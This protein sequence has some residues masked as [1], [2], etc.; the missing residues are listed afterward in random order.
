M[1]SSLLSW[2]NILEFLRPF[3]GYADGHGHVP[4]YSELYGNGV[5]TFC[6]DICLGD[7]RYQTRTCQNSHLD[8]SNGYAKRTSETNAVEVRNSYFDLT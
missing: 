1:G 4:V 8:F 3:L 5:E 2:C 6:G 7:A